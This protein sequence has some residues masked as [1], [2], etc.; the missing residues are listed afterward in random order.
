MFARSSTD[1]TDDE[2]EKSSADFGE[3]SKKTK[4][5]KLHSKQG[6]YLEFYISDIV[7][8]EPNVI[9]SYSQIR[10][11]INYAFITSLE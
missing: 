2:N 7:H 4:K 3:F 10:N 1:D 11:R 8:S 5:Q 9:F 6:L